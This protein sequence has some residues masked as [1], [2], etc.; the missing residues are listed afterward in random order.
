VPTKALTTQRV[1]RAFFVLTW[2]RA[3]LHKRI[4][5]EYRSIISA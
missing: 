5:L 2:Q 1:V 4:Q 3:K